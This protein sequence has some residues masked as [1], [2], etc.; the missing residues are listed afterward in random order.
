MRKLLI[1]LLAAIALSATIKAESYSAGVARRQIPHMEKLL[2]NIGGFI[3][4]GD[5]NT[6]CVKLKEF[7]LLLGMNFEGLQEIRPNTDWFAIKKH[8]NMMDKKYC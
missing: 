1:A 7:D 5:F 3:D 8:T 4:I 6:A 2:K